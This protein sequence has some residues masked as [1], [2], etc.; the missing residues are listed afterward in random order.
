VFSIQTCA[1]PD[2]A[3]LAGYRAAGAYT[4]CYCSE[5]SGGV[6][7]A[8]Y[9]QA[10][11]TTWVFKLE[12]WILGW[13]VSRPSTD[14]QAQQVAEGVIDRFAAWQVEGRSGNQLLMCDFQARTRSWFMVE[15]ID[16]REG[17]RTRLYFGSAVVPV[18]DARTGKA[19]M[20]WLFAALLGFHKVYSIVLLRTALSRLRAASR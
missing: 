19:R 17:V 10:F 7:Q 4:D 16:A 5:V 3:L 12:R 14:A 20:G 18:P 1:L 6:T 2:H 9:V 11:Y 15:H 8:Q 13:A